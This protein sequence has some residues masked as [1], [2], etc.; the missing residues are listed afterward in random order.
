MFIQ[1][2]ATPNPA[3]LKFLP[4]QTVLGSGSADFPTE[5]S[6][7]VSPLAAR[8]ATGTWP[9][10]LPEFFDAVGRPA[11]PTV[12]VALVAT[13]ISAM[14]PYLTYPV[15]KFG[16][17]VIGATVVS[18]FLLGLATLTSVLGAP[19]LYVDGAP[20]AVATDAAALDHHPVAE[21]LRPSDDQL[22]A[23]RRVVALDLELHDP[24]LD[25]IQLLRHRV[26]LDA[27]PRRCLVDQIDRLVGQEAVGDVAI[28]E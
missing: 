15:R 6:A 18:P 23:V 8:L 22:I 28:R 25:R 20:L 2:E 24:A 1:T 5:E 13:V 9:L 7:H 3:T 26:D 17:W 16:W 12:R 11:Y 19:A 4:G 27:E 10:F 14:A 21:V